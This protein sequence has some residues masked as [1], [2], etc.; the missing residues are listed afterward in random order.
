MLGPRPGISIQVEKKRTFLSKMSH[1]LMG[2]TGEILGLRPLDVLGFSP[3]K[4]Q[5]AK[6]LLPG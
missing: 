4:L 6:H 2:K 3:E 5:K 1:V